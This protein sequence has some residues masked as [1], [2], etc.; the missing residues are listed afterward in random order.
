MDSNLKSSDRF[1][2][3]FALVSQ[4]KSVKTDLASFIFQRSFDLFP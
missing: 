2:Q 1:F 4:V 3:D